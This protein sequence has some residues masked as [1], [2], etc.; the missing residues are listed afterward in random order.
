MKE[1]LLYLDTL[2][3]NLGAGEMFIVN[4]ILAFVMFGVALGIKLQTFKDVFRNPKSVILASA[5]SG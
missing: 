4:I 5:C 2:N 3:V 1:H